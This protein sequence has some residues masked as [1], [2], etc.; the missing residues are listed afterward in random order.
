MNLFKNVKITK[1][2][3]HTTAGTTAVPSDAIDMA[4]WDGVAF[5]TTFAV[6]NSGNYL[7]AQEDGADDSGFGAAA[8]LAGSKV[9]PAS[10]NDVAW[11]D[12]YRPIKRYIRVNAT[13]TSSSA[14]GEIYAIQYNGRTLAQTNLVTNEVI[15]KLLISPIAGT[16]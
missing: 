4:N 3:N 5:F 11:L 12:V 8:D 7:T 1:V 10:T 13:R 14:L 2:Q 9:V 15:G 6:A 16:P